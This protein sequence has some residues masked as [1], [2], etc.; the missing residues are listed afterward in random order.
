M[1]LKG[2]EEFVI[3][4][5]SPASTE[6][7]ESRMAVAGLGLG[8][9]GGECADLAKKV[10]FH[11]LEFDDGV[12]QKLIKELGD[13]MFYVAFAARE[14]CGV[15]LEYVINQNMDKLRARYK[16]GKFS[17]DEFLAKERGKG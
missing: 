17:V 16:E 1:D 8:G 7:T 14:V 13:V 4:L 10:L 15:S 2:Y 9:E 6:S 5:M 11:G 12:R 3:G